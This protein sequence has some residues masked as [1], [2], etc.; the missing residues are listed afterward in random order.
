[1]IKLWDLDDYYDHYDYCYDNEDH[2]LDVFDSCVEGD[3]S[4]NDSDDDCLAAEDHLQHAQLPKDQDQDQQNDESWFKTVVEDQ[5]A[6]LV[7]LQN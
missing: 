3:G 4:S 1:M 5:N 6:K 7:C 2:S